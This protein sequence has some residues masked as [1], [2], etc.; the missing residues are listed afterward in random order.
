[1]QPIH[2][3]PYVCLQKFTYSMV[4][5]RFGEIFSCCSFPTWPLLN[6]VLHTILWTSVA[7]NRSPD[8]LA[9]EQTTKPNQN[10]TWPSEGR[11]GG[12]ERGVTVGSFGRIP[13]SVGRSVRRGPPLRR[14][15]S[16]AREGGR[17]CFGS[18]NQH[19][20][21]C[22]TNSPPPPRNSGREREGEGCWA[23]RRTAER[24]ALSR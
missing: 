18:F 17:R 11:E 23:G 24:S 4:R 15:R 3:H 10:T 7:P 22:F 21:P 19:L 20:E 13:I 6:Y 14:S 8:I 1:M 2:P 12:R 5:S 16:L 9:T